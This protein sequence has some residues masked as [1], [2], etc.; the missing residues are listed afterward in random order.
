M[1]KL[2]DA[3]KLKNINFLLQNWD[4]LNMK[5]IKKLYANSGVF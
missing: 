4:M 5:D 2:S 1:K 3:I